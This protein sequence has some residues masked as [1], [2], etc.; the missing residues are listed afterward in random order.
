MPRIPT[1]PPFIR[2][3]LEGMVGILVMGPSPFRETSKREIRQSVP[4]RKCPGED[5][6]IEAGVCHA[7][8]VG[9]TTLYVD[10]TVASGERAFAS[11]MGKSVGAER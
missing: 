5:Q 1:P 8:V 2:W 6:R 3:R 7:S 9:E 11:R 4:V 10:T